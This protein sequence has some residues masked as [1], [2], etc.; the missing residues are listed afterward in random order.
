M[1]RN[2]KQF[3]DREVKTNKNITC[4]IIKV[5]YKDGMEINYTKYS[6]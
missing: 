6:K 4:M 2:Y 5:Y 1:K 3:V